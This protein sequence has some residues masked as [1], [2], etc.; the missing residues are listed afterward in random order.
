MG[1]F[2]YFF[3]YVR[4][5]TEFVL[6][7]AQE[8][9]SAG[10]NLWLDQLDILGGQ[11]WDRAVEEALETC[12]GMIVVL[13]PEALKSNNVMDEVSY[14]LGENK[15]V[16]PVLLRSCAI[17]FRLRR[18][19]YV[20]YT[21]G[22]DVGFSQLLRALN[23]RQSSVVKEPTVKVVREHDG[24]TAIVRKPSKEQMP[25]KTVLVVGDTTAA[26]VTTELRKAKVSITN[27]SSSIGSASIVVIA[28]DT[29]KGPGP[30]HRKI[31]PEIAR[32]RNQKLLWILMKSKNLDHEIIACNLTE[33]QVLLDKHKLPGST[34]NFAVD[35]DSTG[36]EF[37]PPILRGWPAIIRF[38]AGLDLR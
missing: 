34:I 9:R 30:I 20:D 28:Q 36:G 14:A 33:V 17:P 15:L 32:I 25:Q 7:L 11:R 6:K 22:N 27:D 4:S 1:E 13:S 21:A 19:Q 23:L 37:E 35:A 12:Q 29:T 16:V 38:V 18:I 26:E 31:L 5:D 10:V 3:S 24:P 8:L 2:R